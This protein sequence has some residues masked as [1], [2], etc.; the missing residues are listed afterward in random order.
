M[1]NKRLFKEISRIISTVK[2]QK[3]RAG[4]DA[5]SFGFVSQGR[6]RI[7]ENGYAVGEILDKCGIPFCF[8][9]GGCENISITDKMLKS[10]EE[11]LIK[12]T[13]SIPKEKLCPIIGEGDGTYYKKKY[14][15][16][17][18]SLSEKYSFP[19]EERF[20][21][22]MGY[23][24]TQNK[25]FGGNGL[26]YYIDDKVS[27]VR[28]IVLNSV[29]HKYKT[30]ENGALLNEDYYGFGQEQLNWL[31]DVLYDLPKGYAVAL[32]S[33]SPVSNNEN[34]NIR[35]SHVALGIVNAFI[36]GKTYIGEYLN[37][38]DAENNTCVYAVFKGKGEVIG[39]FS[40][41]LLR[42]IITSYHAIS[43][44]RM[45]FKAVTTAN[46]SNE[47]RVDFVVADRKSGDVYITRFG[48][49]E[50]R[51]YNYRLEDL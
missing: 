24:A 11:I 40:G 18:G 12:D 46:S 38:K 51:R 44:R 20:S 16:E 47:L 3:A 6:G 26:Y 50:G 45:N 17:N 13:K 33:H 1:E 42:D 34:S 29:W 21:L 10:R 49:G 30:D 27:K 35:D 4:I 14:C 28:C 36:E 7:G 25:S 19:W 31:C 32:F 8:H 48:N 39:W 9:S 43:G 23:W 41:H 2:E 37:S 5:F 22:Y 15:K